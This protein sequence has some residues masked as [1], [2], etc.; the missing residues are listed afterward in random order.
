MTSKIKEKE[1]DCAQILDNHP[2]VKQWIR[3]VE[4]KEHSFA[5]PRAEKW[6]YPDFVAE[7]NNGTV[8][9]VEYKGAHI[10]NMPSEREKARVG[11]LWERESGGQAFFL[12][13]TQAENAP[14]MEQQIREKLRAIMSSNETDI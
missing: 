8:L 6:F 12:M 4:R 9:V 3:N 10:R 14:S 7:L 1:F 5:L 11:E 2:Q 13:V